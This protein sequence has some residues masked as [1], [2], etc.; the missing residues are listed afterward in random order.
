M[1]G[2]HAALIKLDMYSV[3]GCC[4][5]AVFTETSLVNPLLSC[6][7]LCL[8]NCLILK[9][10]GKHWSCHLSNQSAYFYFGLGD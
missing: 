6:E 2:L 8:A 7:L 3:K 9:M 10:V 5:L 4:L 1:G